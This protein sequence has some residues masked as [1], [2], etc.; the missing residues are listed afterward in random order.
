MN[1]NL[2]VTD[3]DNTLLNDSSKVT[4]ATKEVMTALKEKGVIIAAATGRPLWRAEYVYNENPYIEY[5]ISSNGAVI[6]SIKNS[7]VIKADYMNVEDFN[8][9]IFLFVYIS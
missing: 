1:I 2:V 6:K 8:K 5:V 3:L 9:I 7:E 4:E